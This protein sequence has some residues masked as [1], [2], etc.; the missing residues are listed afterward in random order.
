MLDSQAIIQKT[1]EDYNRIARSFSATR[2][3]VWPEL[4]QFKNLIKNEQKIL[5]WGCGNGHLLQ[6]FSGKNVTYYGLDQSPELIKI[7][8]EL[9]SDQINQGQAKFYCT[10]HRQKKFPANYFDLVFLVA[11]FHHLPD[12]EIRLKLLREIYLA[13]KIGAKLIMT[14]WNLQSP[15]AKS[16]LAKDWQK[17]GDNDYLIPWKDQQP[18]ILAMRYYHHFSKQELSSL[19][20]A[21]GFKI[22][23]IGYFNKNTFSADKLSGRN[24]MVLVER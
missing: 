17:I 3:Y 7:A 8:R 14:V 9:W 10:A 19:L 18:K 13:M 12:D 2:R 5:D 1:K 11:S 23:K 6:L 15:W 21:A 22:K 24:L 16:Q 4:E 20:A